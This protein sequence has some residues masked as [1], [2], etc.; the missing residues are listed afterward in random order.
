MEEDAMAASAAPERPR[1]GRKR[2]E[3]V[4]TDSRDF[5][6][7]QAQRA[8]RERKQAYIKSLED[9]VADLRSRMAIL[10]ADN[11]RLLATSRAASTSPAT[12]EAGLFGSWNQPAI[13]STAAKAAT[14]GLDSTSVIDALKARV[15][16]L[17]AENSMM[18]QTSV[19]VDF[20]SREVHSLVPQPR[21]ATDT[22][23]KCVNCSIEKIRALICMGHVKSLEDKITSL[24][25]EC[26]TLRLISG[27]NQSWNT[28]NPEI[29]MLDA[30]AGAN[31]T[32]STPSADSVAPPNSPPKTQPSMRAG[33][34]PT[35][36]LSAVQ[37]YGP[38]E[39][40]FPKIGLLSLP[41]LKDCKYVNK[42]FETFVKQAN[43]T[44][45]ETLK[46]LM[47]K[48]I[49]L[50]HKIVDRCSIID[51]QKV[52]LNDVIRSLMDSLKLLDIMTVFFER[53]RDH[54]AH[55]D[56]ILYDALKKSVKAKKRR[57]DETPTPNP[58]AANRL[59]KFKETILSI[60]GLESTGNLLSLLDD[61]ILIEAR[62]REEKEDNVLQIIHVVKELNRKCQSSAE[63]MR[64]SWAIESFRGT[65]RWFLDSFSLEDTD[66]E[67]D[68]KYSP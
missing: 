6:N 37:K 38:V 64:V 5:K 46:A 17:E 50:R 39:I 23:A 61:A 22:D 1:V 24:E 14:A 57:L 28:F 45:A 44:S 36:Q 63:R 48:S 20:S 8:F 54:V 62:T 58:E 51:R 11:E 34:E 40:E 25:L 47:L 2:K 42:L 16:A 43:A 53:N 66:D 35:E 3:G 15:M 65:N 55:R 68:T 67:G 19:A 33:P 29:L 9:E 4:P 10:V 21:T 26:Q 60:K 12:V 41:S 52:V 32:F 49:G 59:K 27:S 13:A 31:L 7:L 30:F 18:R 56:R